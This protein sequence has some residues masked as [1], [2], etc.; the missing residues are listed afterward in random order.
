M[1]YDDAV[2]Q[3]FYDL[4]TSTDFSQNTTIRRLFLMFR[5]NLQKFGY[6]LDLSGKWDDATKKQ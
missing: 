2:K 6:A 4:A 5:H 1:W 3:S